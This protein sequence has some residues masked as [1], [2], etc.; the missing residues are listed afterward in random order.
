MRK[1]FSRLHLEDMDA[2]LAQMDLQRYKVELE[3]VKYHKKAAQ[4]ADK[5]L[6]DNPMILNN[7]A[8]EFYESS[9]DEKL[10]AKAVKWA[11]RSI[12]LEKSYPN[13][14]TYG[15]LL[16]KTGQDQK[17]QEVLA[18]AIELAKAEGMD[19]SATENDLKEWLERI[20]E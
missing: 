4:L 8:W 13:M 10:L 7:L 2:Q 15:F 20:K 14:D 17:A 19:Y 18:E 12:E 9:Q 16:F 11:E 3:P 6:Q 1:D 5:Y